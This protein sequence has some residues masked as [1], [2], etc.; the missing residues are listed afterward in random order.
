MNTIIFGKK[1][2]RLENTHANKHTK[3]GNDF[4]LSDNC[5]FSTRLLFAT[6]VRS[7]MCAPLLSRSFIM[8]FRA[9]NNDA[10]YLHLAAG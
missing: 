7:D 1:N 10:K 9:L 2:G 3:I 6:V 5:N 4:M 8:H